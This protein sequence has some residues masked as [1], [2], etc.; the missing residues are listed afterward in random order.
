MVAEMRVRKRKRAGAA[1]GSARISLE[2]AIFSN[3][4][5]ADKREKGDG[6]SAFVIRVPRALA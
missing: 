1:D 3:G 6:E 2:K 4:P 5:L